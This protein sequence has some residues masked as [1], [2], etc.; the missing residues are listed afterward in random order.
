VILLGNILFGVAT[1]TDTAIS[2]VMVLVIVRSVI[3]WLRVD[4]YSQ[5]VRTLF[6][7]TEPLL[8]GIR[9]F[10]PLMG[11]GIDFSPVVLLIA[12]SLIRTVIVQS[13]YDYAAVIKQMY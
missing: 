10:V 3:S 8:R 5:L 11:P 9:R 1:L 7:A 12:L 6:M 13:M 4:P 2:I